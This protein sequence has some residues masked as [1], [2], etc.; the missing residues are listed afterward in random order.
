MGMPCLQFYPVV[1]KNN[2]SLKNSRTTAWISSETKKYEILREG[3]E[4]RLG[5]EW[6][7]S[8]EEGEIGDDKSNGFVEWETGENESNGSQQWEA[9]DEREEQSAD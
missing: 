2:G 6:E 8:E 1:K 5:E 4:S 9:G 3:E 7:I